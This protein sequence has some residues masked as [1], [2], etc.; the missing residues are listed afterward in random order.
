MNLTFR[1]RLP[2]LYTESFYV[3]TSWYSKGFGYRYSIGINVGASESKG[4]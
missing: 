4:D 2:Y 3:M 1:E